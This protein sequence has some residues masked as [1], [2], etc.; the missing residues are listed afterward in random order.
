MVFS[1]ILPINAD[2]ESPKK[3]I[4][5]GILPTDVICNEGLNLAIRTSGDVICIRPETAE[6]M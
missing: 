2:I 1:M 6:K 4:Q 5:R 3:Q